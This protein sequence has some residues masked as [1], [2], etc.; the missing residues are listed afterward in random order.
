VTGLTNGTSYTFTV[1]ATNSVG[2]SAAST[3]STAVTLCPTSTITDIDGNI[4]PTV[5][6]GNQCWM[7]ENLKTSRYN[8]GDSIPIVTG[9]TAWRSLTTGG[10]SWYNNDST[11]YENPYG[12]LYNW[13]AARESRDLCPTGWGV[14]TD[15]EWTTLTTYLG[16][17][18]VAGSKMKATGAT[19]W[20]SQSAGT[21]NS[22]GFSALPGGYRGSGGNFFNV[23]NL[24]FFWSDTVFDANDAYL[25]NLDVTNGIVTRKEYSK[26]VGASVRCL[27]D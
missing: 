19:Y 12:N 23:S 26:L 16:G 9:T 15:A 17:L 4:Y 5:S 27:R 20:S 18:N 7:R 6:I 10:R 3:A 21:D 24:A 2:N 1:I 25:R 8:N 22:S 14:P 13:Y 11:T